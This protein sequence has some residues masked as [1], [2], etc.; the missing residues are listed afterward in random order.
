MR[1]P[2]P[3][4]LGL[5]LDLAPFTLEAGATLARHRVHAFVWSTE[6]DHEA[7]SSRRR[8]LPDLPTVL[9]LHALTQRA[10]VSGP[11]GFWDSL[12]GEGRPLRPWAHRILSFNLLGSCF[13]TTGP[14]DSDFP[15]RVY[16]TR[17]PACPPLAR[18]MPKHD[19]AHLPATVTTWDQA[20]SVLLALDALGIERVSLAT[21][22]SIG[23]MVAMALAMLAPERVERV[24]CIAAPLAASAWM[25][26]WNH[27]A[28]EAVLADPTYPEAKRG[29]GVARQIARMTYRTPE[30]L[31][32]RQ[33]R[34]IAGPAHDAK[35]EWSSRTPYRV[36]TYL[37]HAADIFDFDARSYVVMTG[38]MDH[39]DLLR[40]P[41]F[42]GAEEWGLSRIRADV[43]LVAIESDLLVPHP[44][45]E[46]FGNALR[47]AG[48][49]MIMHELA[50]VRG[51]DAFLCEHSAMHRILSHVLSKRNEPV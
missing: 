18:G 7:L 49:R 22:G 20:K 16:D 10:D 28:R 8:A 38:A 9:V 4:P 33:G 24:A 34:R 40:P 25:I 14:T 35:D 36:E 42:A 44:E 3:V 50:S 17:F 51:H 2:A 43:H 21:G 12:V 29:L 32:E 45:M 11:N 27:A 39:H 1:K 5:D 26:G 48:V 37:D 23:G 47:A 19:D 46:A 6:D 41:P 13:G 31:A 15:R 30:S